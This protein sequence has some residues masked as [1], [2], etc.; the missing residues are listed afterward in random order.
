M[1][2]FENK[3]NT[4]LEFY[5][6]LDFSVGELLQLIQDKHHFSVLKLP[7]MQS[8]GLPKPLK[9]LNLDEK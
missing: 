3:I 2:K 8:R 7:K 5:M 6:L 9:I 4:T 1:Q